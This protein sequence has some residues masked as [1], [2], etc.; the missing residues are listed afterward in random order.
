MLELHNGIHFRSCCKTTS[1]RISHSI[2]KQNL[3]LFLMK[4]ARWANLGAV[5]LLHEGLSVT[6][7]ACTCMPWLSLDE[8]FPEAFCKR[9]F[10]LFQTQETRGVLIMMKKLCFRCWIARAA[11]MTHLMKRETSWPMN[12]LLLSRWEEK[13]SHLIVVCKYCPTAAWE[14][15]RRMSKEKE[16]DDGIS[17]AAF[18]WGLLLH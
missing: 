15:G 5:W 3:K 1:N 12:I 2:Y 9:L 16:Q 6:A 7:S 18:L 11:M 8:K 13:S 14:N 4:F 17:Y 10:T